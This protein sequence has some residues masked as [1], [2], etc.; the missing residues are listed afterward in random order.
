MD[1]GQELVLVDTNVFVIDLRYRR[2]I[3]YNTSHA[4]L[5]KIGR[6]ER[7]FT[8]LINLM[9]VCGILSFNFNEQQLTDLWM[10]FARKFRLSVLPS[11]DFE[12]ELPPIALEHLFRLMSKKSSFGDAL[13]IATA[14]RYLPFIST[15]VTWDIEHLQGVFRG[16]V[17]TPE[18]YLAGV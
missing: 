15:L 2:D 12:A 10:H 9:E 3:H 7:G 11:P 18:E 14:E 4:F 1:A 5:E 13:M 16:R 17:L 6:S 8:T